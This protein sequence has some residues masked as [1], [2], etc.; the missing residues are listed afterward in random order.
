MGEKLE[1]GV[2]LIKNIWMSISMGIAFF[3]ILSALGSFL[4][5]GS[6]FDWSKNAAHAGYRRFLFSNIRL[7]NNLR[8]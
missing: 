5:F 8:K 4:G 3:L 2:T 1:K 6:I 7:K